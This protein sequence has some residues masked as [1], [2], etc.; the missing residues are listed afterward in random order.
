MKMVRSNV[1]ETNSSSTHA[2]VVALNPDKDNYDLYSFHSD[3]QFG[4]NE[5]RMIS[6]WDEKLVYTY[7]VL[8]SYNSSTTERYSSAVSD[9]HIERFK[10]NVLQAYKQVAKDCD[11]HNDYNPEQLFMYVDISIKDQNNF[12]VYD[13]IIVKYDDQSL[14]RYRALVKGVEIYLDGDSQVKFAYWDKGE[15]KIRDPKEDEYM[16]A[17]ASIE[18]QIRYKFPNDVYVDHIEGLLGNGFIDKMINADSNYLK[19]F[20]FNSDSYITIGSDEYHGFYVRT[21]GF[22]N[23]YKEQWVNENGQM[24]PERDPNMSSEQWI[25]ICDQYNEI[26]SEF[27]RKLREYEKDHDVFLKGN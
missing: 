4:R 13:Q 15:Q 9:Q 8:K 1:F 3:Y 22:Q 5:F 10:Q 16:V 17:E 27:Y 19:S 6:N 24:M 2:L 26:D 12:D 20:I 7:Y 18:D 25:E 11:T 14:V 21:I 23:D